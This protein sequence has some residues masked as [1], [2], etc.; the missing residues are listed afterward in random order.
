MKRLAS[1]LLFASSLA[2]AA[3][4]CSPITANEVETVL[5]EQ[6]SLLG[7]EGGSE[8]T[9]QLVEFNINCLSAAS[10]RGYA[11]TTV[12]VNY[13]LSTTPG[14]YF[15]VQLNIICSG[16]EWDGSHDSNQFISSQDSDFG[17]GVATAEELLAAETNT[18]CLRCNR[19]AARD[20]PNPSHCLRKH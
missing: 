6:L 9:V 1:F 5:S 3:S 11:Q 15:V 13:T 2:L 8:F 20:S 10:T 17:G 18:S 16:A 7:G 19:I 14:E 12:T 4:Q